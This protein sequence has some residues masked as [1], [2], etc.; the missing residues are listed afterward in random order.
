L[1]LIV[2][3]EYFEARK[4]LERDFRE[5]FAGIFRRR[6]AIVNGSEDMEDAIPGFWYIALSHNRI[7][8]DLIT[9]KDIE[10]L[11]ALE[12]IRCVDVP[13][14]NDPN[15]SHFGFRLEFHFSENRFFKNKVLHK[16]YRVPNFFSDNAHPV[17]ESIEGCLVVW[18]TEDVDLTR[19]RVSNKLLDEESNDDSSYSM[20]DDNLAESFFNFFGA[21]WMENARRLSNESSEHE[22]EEHQLLLEQVAADFRTGYEIYSKIV[23]EALRWFTGEAAD[24]DGDEDDQ[25][26][27]DDD[28]EE[29]SDEDRGGES[30]SGN[31]SEGATSAASINHS[32]GR[33]S[34][35]STE[36]KQQGS[37]AVEPKSPTASFDHMQ[38]LANAFRKATIG[39]DS[40]NQ[41]DGLNHE[42][43]CK[44]Q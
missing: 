4:A 28:E 40:Q 42:Q 11:E 41:H 38:G 7:V 26:D 30:E 32:R 35:T 8:A 25:D 18:K 1:Y 9:E 13:P 34:G 20:G 17:L 39:H 14:S 21:P 29:D 5:K 24:D 6:A 27:E 2:Q 31:E 36:K 23:P 3:D 33:A 19:A 43:N 37:V 15:A 12:D 10:A 16:T 22:Q 44:Q